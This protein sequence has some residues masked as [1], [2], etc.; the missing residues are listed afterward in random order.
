MLTA[1]GHKYVLSECCPPNP[2][3]IENVTKIQ[4]KDYKYWIKADEMAQCYILASMS[5]VLQHQHQSMETAF[6]MMTN[7]TEMFGHQNRAA[8]QV[9]MRE[10]LNIKM[11]EGT[12]VRDH[13]LK[14]IGLLNELEILEAQIDGETQVDIMLNSLAK[15]FKHFC[16]NYNMH[17]MSYSL[18]EL[19][20]ELV[21]A[22][23]LE[24]N[25][26]SEVVLVTEKG[27]T[28]KSKG[29]KK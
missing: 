7:L 14:M 19:L 4:I 27:S 9:A 26:K 24:E 29:K 13:V 20:K 16:L 8:R 15:R 3:E 1:E 6:D 12:P 23:G 2:T 17:K 10:V 18:T 25:N 21:S 28:S 22:D 5:N 11:A